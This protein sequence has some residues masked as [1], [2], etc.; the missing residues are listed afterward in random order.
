MLRAGREH[1]TRTEAK[2]THA[3]LCVRGDD[4]SVGRKGLHE[5]ALSWL[6]QVG[7]I[8]HT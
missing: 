3:A 4:G 2:D 8:R 1:H 5:G 6:L 7:R